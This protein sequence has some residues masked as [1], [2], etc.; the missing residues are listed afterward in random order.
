MPSPGIMTHQSSLTVPRHW[1][2]TALSNSYLEDDKQRIATTSGVIPSTLLEDIKQAWYQT[3]L[4]AEGYAQKKKTNERVAGFYW[5]YEARI[6][7]P[8]AFRR[9]NDRAPPAP[10][11]PIRG[12]ELVGRRS[13]LLAQVLHKVDARLSEGAWYPPNVIFPAR[14]KAVQLFGGEWFRGYLERPD[15]RDAHLHMKPENFC[16][17][18]LVW[19]NVKHPDVLPLF[20]GLR[21]RFDRSRKWRVGWHTFTHWTLPISH[22]DSLWETPAPGSSELCTSAERDPF[23][24]S[25]PLPL[26]K[27]STSDYSTPNPSTLPRETSMRLGVRLS[28]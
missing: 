12:D 20:L 21:I 23:G 27:H 3:I 8:L 22:G 4:Q 2:Y 9:D 25:L 28:R 16:P 13:G 19:R 11:P 26:S 17:E 5:C 24:G 10:R 14:T 18:A 6:L 15:G 1:C 7:L